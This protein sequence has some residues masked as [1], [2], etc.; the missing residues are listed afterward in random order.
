M[1]VL[2]GINKFRFARMKRQFAVCAKLQ[3][4]ASDLRTDG[5]GVGHCPQAGVAFVLNPETN[6]ISSKQSPWVFLRQ[7]VSVNQPT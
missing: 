7:P 4:A 2:L 1:M 3:S 6:R 5:M